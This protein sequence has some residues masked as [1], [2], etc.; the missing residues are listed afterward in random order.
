MTTRDITVTPEYRQVFAWLRGGDTTPDPQMENSFLDLITTAVAQ[1]LIANRSEYERMARAA[2]RA[3]RRAS[4]PSGCLSIKAMLDE[5]RS[6]THAHIET[7]LDAADDLPEAEP[8]NDISTS[9]PIVTTEEVSSTELD[10]VILAKALRHMA[11]IEEK[12]LTQSQIQCILYIAYGVRLAQKEERLTAEHPQMWQYG[13]VF[14]RAYNRLR[15]DAD[16][17]FE[18][19]DSLRNEHPGI[20]KYLT[21]CFRR[22]AWT[23]ACILVSPHIADGSPWA[24]TRKSNPDGWGARIEDDLIR[25]WFLPRV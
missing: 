17:G 4:R 20:F 11:L 1:R 15:K 12:E 10:S 5:V 25:E 19:Y 2:E 14:P 3:E 24:E 8:V 16:D 6:E 7:S 22:Y 23:K 18:E 13:P 9:Q 21:N